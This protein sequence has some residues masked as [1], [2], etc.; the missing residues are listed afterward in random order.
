MNSRLAYAIG[1]HPW[2]ELA[3]HPPFAGKLL[4][5]VAH[6]EEGRE[7][8]YGPALDLGTGS[9]V[10]GV[11]LAKRGWQVTGVDIVENALNRARDRADAEGVDMRIV[12]GDVTALRQSEVGSGYRLVLDTGT[13]HGLT[14]EQRE[15]MAADVTAVCADDATVMLDCFAPRRRGPLPRGASRDD[16]QRAFRGWKITGV[17]IADSEPDALARLMKFDERFYRLR[18][19]GSTG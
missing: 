13:F 1:F 2:E 19:N 3:E 18:R 10:W 12:H 14:D 8:P 17:E 6:E 4:E 11:Q 15:K 7:P 16:V 5:L 9:G